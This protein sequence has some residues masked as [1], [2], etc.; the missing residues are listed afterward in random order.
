LAASQLYVVDPG[1]LSF[2][3][4]CHAGLAPDATLLPILSPGRVQ[5]RSEGPDRSQPWAHPEKRCPAPLESSAG[6]ARWFMNQGPPLQ[7]SGS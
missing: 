5:R 3:E 6:T 4:P 1:R 2:P 7:V